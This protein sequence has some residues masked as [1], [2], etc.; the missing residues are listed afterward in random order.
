MCLL[1]L[2]VSIICLQLGREILDKR[3]QFNLIDRKIRALHS[4]LV[5]A[6]VMDC[7][8]LMRAGDK[9]KQNGGYFYKKTKRIRCNCQSQTTMPKSDRRFRRKFID[10]DFDLLTKSQSQSSFSATLLLSLVKEK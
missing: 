2:P 3:Y 8:D 7:G 4:Q 9:P 5:V 10:T 6:K 1:E